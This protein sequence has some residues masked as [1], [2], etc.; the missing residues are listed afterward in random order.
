MRLKKQGHDSASILTVVAMSVITMGIV[1]GYQFSTIKD[2][3]ASRYSDASDQCSYAAVAEVHKD[4]QGSIFSTSEIGNLEIVNSRGQLSVMN[5]GGVARGSYI[6][7]NMVFDKTRRKNYAE[8][9]RASVTL[10]KLD[11]QVWKVKGVFCDQKAGSVRGCPPD[12]EIARYN[13]EIKKGIRNA[14]VIPEFRVNCG[15]DLTYGWVLTKRVDAVRPTITPRPSATPR[16]FITS[17]LTAIPTSAIS[18]RPSTTPRPTVTPRPTITPRITQPAIGGPGNGRGGLEVQVVALNYPQRT[19]LWS[20]DHVA[21]YKPGS[22]TRQRASDNEDPRPLYLNPF[23]VRATCVS[24]GCREGRQTQIKVDKYK[25]YAN[26][27]DLDPGNY[28]LDM[29]SMQKGYHEWPECKATWQVKANEINKA[30]VIILENEVKGTY[31]LR[32]T[33]KLCKDARGIP[34]IVEGLGGNACYFANGT[35]KPNPTNPIAPTQAE[36]KCKALDQTCNDTYREKCFIGNSEGSQLCYKFGKCLGVGDGTKCSWGSGSYCESCVPKSGL[37]PTTAIGGPAN[38]RVNIRV[39]SN[40][41]KKVVVQLDPCPATGPCLQ[42]L[43]FNG[44]GT[45]QAEFKVSPTDVRYKVKVADREILYAQALAGVK[46]KSERCTGIVERVDADYEICIV[47]A[48]SLIQLLVTE[49][50]SNVAPPAPL[51]PAQP[52]RQSRCGYYIKPNASKPAQSR[53]FV[54]CPDDPHAK[55]CSPDYLRPYFGEFG[56]EVLRQAAGTCWNESRGYVQAMND[57]CLNNQVKCKRGVG[58][59]PDCWTHDF[60]SGLFQINQIGVCLDSTYSENQTRGPSCR[61]KAGVDP[62]ACIDQMGLRTFDGNL[63]AA[64]DYYVRRGWQPWGHQCVN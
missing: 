18:P 21:S 9:D 30:P 45:K 19:P 43:A 13:R 6:N 4:V 41:I 42:T 60:S 63:K 37:V 52:P 12:S 40:S 44:I 46:V 8:N 3:L 5:E 15:V 35:N 28:K 55:Y 24:G 32:T 34:H 2:Q 14:M 38:L 48:P 26:F 58:N 51:P 23:E 50:K 27:S 62:Y 16:L 25:G 56:E 57:R 22:C 33:E 61:R 53:C 11:T 7:E 17:Q 36:Q 31:E 64:K 47:K 49:I 20:S 59:P 29:R 54:A 1:L 10:K 39:D